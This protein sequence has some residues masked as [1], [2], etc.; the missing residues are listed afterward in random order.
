M[1][2][3]LKLNRERYKKRAY[4]FLD[5]NFTGLLC[6]NTNICQNVKFIITRSQN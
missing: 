6:L 3:I 5:Q 1:R 2:E 4:D